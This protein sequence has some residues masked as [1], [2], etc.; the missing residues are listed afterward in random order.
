MISIRYYN[1][2][3]FTYY[4]NGCC[5][6]VG[7]TLLTYGL[8]KKPDDVSNDKKGI[9]YCLLTIYPFLLVLFN[10][11]IRIKP[12]VNPSDNYEDSSNTILK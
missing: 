2:E 8:Y 4:I 11:V 12:F 7:Y 6:I 1:F 10:V 3:E 5:F 9:L